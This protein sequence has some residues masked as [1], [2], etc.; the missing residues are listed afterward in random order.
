MAD[1][2]VLHHAILCGDSRQAGNSAQDALADGVEP[3]RLLAAGVIPAMDEARRRPLT[4]ECSV[5]EM[6]VA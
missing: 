2:T 3:A 6:L 5:S 4:H 1:L